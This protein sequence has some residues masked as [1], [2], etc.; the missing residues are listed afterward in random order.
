MRMV[1]KFEWGNDQPRIRMNRLGR[2]RHYNSV[3]YY[4]NK[5]VN[6]LN[7]NYLLV[8]GKHDFHHDLMSIIY[9]FDLPSYRSIII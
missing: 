5:A 2:V 1:G 7:K 8:L 6:Q 9:Q 3:Q 4:K